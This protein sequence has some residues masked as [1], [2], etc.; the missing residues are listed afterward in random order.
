MGAS[1]SL[2]NEGEWADPSLKELIDTVEQLQFDI[3]T[4]HRKFLDEQSRCLFK[5][6]DQIITLLTS[7]TKR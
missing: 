5:K 7:K 1:A 6:H 3:S 2:L 4:T